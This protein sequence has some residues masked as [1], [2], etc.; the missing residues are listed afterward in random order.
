M[1]PL[2]SIITGTFNRLALLQ[3]L[4]QS[5]R[6]D[7]PDGITYEFIVCD[8]GSTDGTLDWLRGQP[9]T[10]LIEHGGLKG[11][12]EAFTDCGKQARGKYTLILNDDVSVI[13]GSILRAIIYLEEH[14]ACGQVAFA[15]NRPSPYHPQ[16]GFHT[17]MQMGTRDGSDVGIVYAQCGMV[18]TWLAQRVN[19]W[20]GS[21]EQDFKA[22]TYA[23][24]NLLSSNI[25]A[26]GYSV[27]ALD[28][29][30]VHDTVVG[31]M[32]R[33][34]NTSEGR[35][36]A[37]SAEFYRIFPTGPAIPAT[38]QADQEDK[39]QLRILYLP[40]YEPGFGHYK[41]GLRD[42]LA[43]HFIVYELDYLALREPQAVRAELNGI[44]DRFQPDMLLTQCHDARLVTPDTLSSLR[45]YHPRLVVVNW[46]GDY[47]P[48]N[49]TSSEMLDL[50]RQVDLQL[51]VN[52]SVIETYKAHHIPAAYWQIGY[53]DTPDPLPESDH[54][55]IVFLGTAYSERRKQLGE[56][57]MSF[58][59]HDCYIG[60]YGD[61]WPASDSNTLYDFP[62]GAALYRNAK[63]S[64]G[65]N[66]FSDAYGFVSNRIFQ[67]LSAGGALLLHQRV[68]GLAELTGI[69]AG[70]H[71]IAWEDF[72]GLRATIEFWLKPENDA[73]RRQIAEA[74]TAFV[75][76][77]HS[78]D[79]RVRELFVEPGLI[80]Q[81]RRSPNRMVALLFK[82][83]AERGGVRGLVTGKQYEFQKVNPLVVDMLDVDG[84]VASGLWQKV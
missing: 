76:V 51:V 79:A 13:A 47:W 43:K 36:E 60:L 42:A 62:K 30:R 75:R 10:T 33:A 24:D 26:L 41:S 50:L 5:V 4:F 61:G 32:L 73:E 23:G 77:Q 27:D 69:T 7:V 56:L 17:L 16:G 11:A 45:A 44:C 82:G 68:P 52:A 8:G 57:I 65:D 29:C 3:A 63:L 37:D 74:G 46:N 72:D 12:I 31:D 54:H 19:W 64:I 9:N 71:Y 53:E 15:D 21:P 59:D 70:V 28:G 39:R 14:P 25:W 35:S 40:I 49:L 48:A 83:A 84:F 66:Q 67:A 20:R 6:D 78:F 58:A 38:L 1:K 55:E 80:K 34:F 81:A 2:L 18:R 22:R